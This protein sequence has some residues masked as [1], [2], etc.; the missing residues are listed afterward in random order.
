M[1]G[2]KPIAL[3]A[4]DNEDLKAVSAMLQDAVVKIG[5]IAYLKEE[6]RFALV[7]NRYCWE[8]KRSF[9]HPGFRVRAGLHFDDV[10]TV[11]AKSVRLDA[12]DAII[13]ILSVAWE[14]EEN[15]GTITLELAGG[16]TIALET[17][18]INVTVKDLSAPWRA[19][20]RPQ[21]EGQ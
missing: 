6:R 16:G 11:R 10:K 5:D 21:H 2:Y 15:G 12:K 13:D 4:A 8:V 3:M 9:M 7:A 20:R 18:A 14:G 17:E 19:A 1:A